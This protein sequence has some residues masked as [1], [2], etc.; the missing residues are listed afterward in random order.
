MTNR[1]AWP[2]VLLLL[3]LLRFS[4]RRSSRRPGCHD[5][6]AQSLWFQPLSL[7]CAA[8][9]IKLPSDWGRRHVF[10]HHLKPSPG[11]PPQRH[12]PHWEGG[13]GGGRRFRI[14]TRA[15][16]QP[17]SAAAAAA[18]A[19]LEGLRRQLQDAVWQ[20]FPGLRAAMV[21]MGAV[22]DGEVLGPGGRLSRRPGRRAGSPLAFAAAFR[23]VLP[24][25]CS[26]LLSWRV[27]T[28]WP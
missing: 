20:R 4:V 2:W 10:P 5:H 23:S 22:E 15:S 6:V 3:L 14:P 1:S 19:V 27:P 24:A 28:E 8:I 18:T 26:F 12:P 25:I 7:A 21:C 11:G 17:A 13:G 9:V 16:V